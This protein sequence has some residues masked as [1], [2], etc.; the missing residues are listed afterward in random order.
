MH[1]KAFTLIEIVVV[2]AILA[3]VGLVSTSLFFRNIRS[4]NRSDSTSEVS[5]NAQSVLSAVDR[6]VRNARKVTSVCPSTSSTISLMA[7]DDLEVTFSLSNNRIAS[8]GA[9]L[10]SP[11]ITVENL[12]F[13]CARTEGLPDS[14]T[15][16]FDVTHNSAAE[17]S[18]TTE[19]FTQTT[20]LRNFE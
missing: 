7:S 8:N 6:F 20:N 4:T 18:L 2:I 13:V 12:Q 17:D 14:I 5:Q 16:S 15:V 9:Y 11:S 10:T 1:N 19:T 3:I